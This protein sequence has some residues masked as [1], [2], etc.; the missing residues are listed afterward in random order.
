MVRNLF[1]RIDMFWLILAVILMTYYFQ[2]LLSSALA[3]SKAATVA[4]FLS[5]SLDSA[6]GAA[7]QVDDIKVMIKVFNFMLLIEILYLIL[8]TNINYNFSQY[9]D[10]FV[11]KIPEKIRKYS[12]LITLWLIALFGLSALSSNAITFVYMIICLLPLIKNELERDNGILKNVD[13]K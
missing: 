8:A 1:K 9:I 7:N 2:M 12:K 4:A 11:E 6:V 13:W 10:K 3:S 5:G